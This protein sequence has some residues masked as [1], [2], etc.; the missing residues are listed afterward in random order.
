MGCRKLFVKPLK[1]LAKKLNLKKEKTR[2]QNASINDIDALP[3]PPRVVPI[4]PV[5]W[6]AEREESD[7]GLH[8]ATLPQNRLKVPER[9]SSLPPYLKVVQTD[10]KLLPPVLVKS[11]SSEASNSSTD[12]DKTATP[13]P[14]L[15]ATSAY[16]PHLDSWQPISNHLQT[17]VNQ[18][19]PSHEQDVDLEPAFEGTLTIYK[20]F[21]STSD[22][23]PSEVSRNTLWDTEEK[24]QGESTARPTA[25]PQQ[26]TETRTLLQLLGT[27]DFRAS[28]EIHQLE[29]NVRE[30][31]KQKVNAIG[32]WNGL[33]DDYNQLHDLSA[34]VLGDLHVQNAGL[35]SQI[36][37]LESDSRTKQGEF[38]QLWDAAC[39]FEKEYNESKGENGVLQQRINALEAQLRAA[40]N[41]EIVHSLV[42]QASNSSHSSLKQQVADL[43]AANSI[44]SSIKAENNQLKLENDGLQE[45][46]NFAA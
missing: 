38:D 1:A 27:Y 32:Q 34:Q 43:E 29:K 28:F 6:V 2:Q 41:K 10:R 17:A 14:A 30:F 24:Q 35:Q 45:K 13:R 31:E 40:V 46:L 22:E 21:S 4:P 19:V 26:P 12:E 39:Y 36:I 3:T 5:D 16:S 7:T 33:V 20:P 42:V 44:S 37:A 11:E 8:K 23:S 25:S 18:E 15:T 9:T